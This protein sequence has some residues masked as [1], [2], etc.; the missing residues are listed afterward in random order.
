MPPTTSGEKDACPANAQAFATVQRQLLLFSREDGGDILPAAE[1]GHHLTYERHKGWVLRVTIQRG[2]K[3]V[4]KRL[5]FYLKTR[6]LAEAEKA[7]ELVLATLRRLGLTVKLRHQ[8]KK[9]AKES[10]AP[11][12]PS[13]S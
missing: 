10:F 9:G 8:K 12:K 4:G 2:Q 3:V 1:G 5:K 7:R 11:A 13:I 6:E